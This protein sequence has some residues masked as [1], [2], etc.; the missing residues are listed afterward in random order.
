[1]PNNNTAAA[2]PSKYEDPP[3]QKYWHWS[4][5][6]VGFDMFGV[7]P[8]LEIR[9]KRKK[10]SCWGAFVSMVA[11]GIISV[12]LLFQIMETQKYTEQGQQFIKSV[13]GE[14]PAFFYHEF[15]SV[16][17]AALS[18]Y[19]DDMRKYDF[20][21]GTPFEISKPQL[22]ED[23]IELESDLVFHD[24]GAR[25]IRNHLFMYMDAAALLGG[26]VY[27]IQMVFST[28]VKCY[29]RKLYVKEVLTDSYL[30]QKNEGYLCVPPG[31]L[32]KHNRKS[33]GNAPQ[34]TPGRDSSQ[35]P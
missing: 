23:L 26:F 2:P 22:Q 20:Y 5:F 33:S 21:L 4:D 3:R 18:K 35:T 10:K 9:G 25:L 6:F 16:Q 30:L 29:N 12:F 11:I 7:R 31:Y 28:A 1:M 24:K 15:D 32:S 34:P 8:T 13:L 19:Y 27:F 17:I 14:K